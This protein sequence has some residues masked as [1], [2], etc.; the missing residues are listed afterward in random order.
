M[1]SK[2]IKV[3][4]NTYSR[5]KKLSEERKSSI[6]DVV[7]SITESSPGIEDFK[8]SWNLSD[9]KAKEIREEREELWENWEV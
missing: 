7:D 8:G 5:L 1:S 6:K 9:E 2:A 3:S 4:E